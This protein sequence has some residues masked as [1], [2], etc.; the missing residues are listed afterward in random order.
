MSDAD[1][2]PA[3]AFQEAWSIQVNASALGFDWA[4]V[5]PVMDKVREELDEI[6]AAL[7]KGD[8]DLAKR[9]LGD[10]LFSAVNVA[11]FLDANPSEELC[12][13]NRR[14]RDRFDRLAA[15]VRK[16]GRVMGECTLDELDEV[17][18][19]IKAS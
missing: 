15:A 18:E 11:R 4:H 19:R 13:A 9:E 7:D 16:T 12:R 6:Q 2:L 10:L 8:A 17:W 3:D 5:S 14:F 1:R